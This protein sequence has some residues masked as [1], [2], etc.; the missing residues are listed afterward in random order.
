M[1]GQL[2]YHL[3]NLLDTIDALYAKYNAFLL[4]NGYSPKYDLGN[5]HMFVIE[6]M[7]KIRKIIEENRKRK[8]TKHKKISYNT[9]IEINSCSPL[10]LL[11]LQKKLMWIAEG[12]GIGFVFGKGKHKPEIQKLYEELEE[13]ETL[14]ME[15]KEF[16]RAWGKAETAIR[17]Q[18]WKQ[19]SCG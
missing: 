11:K 14:M 19:P 4:E 2:Y 3:T 8:L 9:I 17:K 15:Y 16:L 1:A 6:G 13:C 5:A 10:E 7:D 12:E 18:T